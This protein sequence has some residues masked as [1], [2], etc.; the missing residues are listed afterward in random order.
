VRA[1]R[2]LLCT[3]A[4][5]G[6][7]ACEPPPFQGFEPPRQVEVRLREATFDPVN[8]TLAVGGTVTWTNVLALAHTITPDDA[9]RPGTW[10]AQGLDAP[11]ARFAHTFG[12][13]GEFRYRCLVHG[14]MAVIRVQ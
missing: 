2:G 10:T 1:G 12:L 11:G 13:A 9:G 14:D 8:V 5:W 4:L 6:A 3:L 7:V